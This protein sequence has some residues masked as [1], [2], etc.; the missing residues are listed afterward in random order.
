MY[1][2]LLKNPQIN[3]K[4]VLQVLPYKGYRDHYSVLFAGS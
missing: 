3:P 4:K 2:Y 1:F